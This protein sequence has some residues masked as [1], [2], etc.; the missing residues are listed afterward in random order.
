MKRKKYNWNLPDAIVRRLG[1][2]TYGRQRVIHEGDDLLIILHSVPQADS[3]ERDHKVFWLRGEDGQWLCNGASNG[4]FQL[5]A[6]VQ[7]YRDKLNQLEALDE[8]ANSSDQLFAIM[9]PLVPVYRASVNLHVTLQAAREACRHDKLLL[10]VR[11]RAY[12]QQRRYEI[13]LTDTKTALDYRIAKNAEF[14]AV[15]AQEAVDAQH[16]LNILAAI[17]FPL[18][19]LATIFGMNLVHGMEEGSPI[20]FWSVFVAGIALGLFMKRWVLKR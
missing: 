16:R 1:P 5:R 4:E 18:T 12:E 13:L 9:E 3:K 2:D 17:F 8:G 14:Q 19:A 10:E 15:K 7:A 11:D 6:L 20:I